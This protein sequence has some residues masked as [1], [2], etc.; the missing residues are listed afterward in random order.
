MRSVVFAIICDE[1][2]GIRSKDARLAL[3]RIGI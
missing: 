1:T 2:F 3:L